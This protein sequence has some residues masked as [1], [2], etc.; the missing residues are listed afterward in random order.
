MGNC[1]SSNNK[2]AKENK[3]QKESHIPIL[4]NVQSNQKDFP[5][6]KKITNN[7]PHSINKINDFND[8]LNKSNNI[9]RSM[10]LSS[11]N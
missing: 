7:N 4:A 10:S 11:D 9:E 1:E 3:K 8:D 5:S 2:H 6:K